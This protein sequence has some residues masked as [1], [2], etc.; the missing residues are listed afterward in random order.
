MNELAQEDQLAAALARAKA[1]FRV[2]QQTG[3][4]PFFKTPANPQG[5]PYATTA[6]IDAAISS[7]LSA[8][9]FAPVTVH[10]RLVDGHW[11]AR[12]V[13][14]HKSGQDIQAEVPLFIGKQDM[15][16]FKSALTYAQRML[17][18]C[19]TGCV[20]GADDDDGNAAV[21]NQPAAVKGNS[22]KRA[23]DSMTA[24]NELRK[25]LADGD[26]PAA[27]KALDKVRLRA[28]RK[29]I[30]EDLLHRAEAAYDKA[31]PKEEPV[32]V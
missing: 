18:V 4:N 6:D 22:A 25:A 20:S 1:S 21:N 17:I 2:A 27:K 23:V 14:R 19:L 3:R 5:A 13:L 28:K 7:A 12:G 26:E 32:N 8:E 11:I 30:D 9:G 15:Q 31:F 24:E 29:E 10:P 16:G